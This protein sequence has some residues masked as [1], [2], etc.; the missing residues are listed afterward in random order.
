MQKTNL[1]HVLSFLLTIFIAVSTIGAFHIGARLFGQS[2]DASETILY[3]DELGSDSLMVDNVAAT[4]P[5]SLIGWGKYIVHLLW[6]TFKEILLQ[7]FIN[8]H[9]TILLAISLWLVSLIRKFW[10]NSVPK[11]NNAI[12]M[13]FNNTSLQAR[14]AIKDYINLLVQNSIDL[15][16]AAFLQLDAQKTGNVEAEQGAIAKQAQSKQKLASAV[17]LAMQDLIS[18]GM[19]K[20][21]YANKNDNEIVLELI[22]AIE[23]ELMRKRIEQL[24]AINVNQ[25][26]IAGLSPVS[27]H[28]VWHT[29]AIISAQKDDSVL[30]TTNTSNVIYASSRLL[31]SAKEKIA[32]QYAQLIQ[33]NIDGMIQ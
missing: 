29:A 26:A 22:N 15:T 16:E 31:A 3:S 21:A 8:L 17:T 7:A 30:R 10:F 19:H 13:Y 27:A 18:G 11:L 5:A 25:G 28:P 33:N 1:N 20:I 12:D 32:P 6:N 2:D 23:K 9:Q 4:P 14:N 24:E